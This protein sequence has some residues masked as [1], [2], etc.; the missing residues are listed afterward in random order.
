MVRQA[1]PYATTF[2]SIV[3]TADTAVHQTKFKFKTP[4][5][6]LSSAQRE[7]KDARVVLAILGYWETKIQG[8]RHL[9]KEREGQPESKPHARTDCTHFQFA[10]HSPGVEKH[11]ATEHLGRQ[12]EVKL[13][14]AGG[15][16]IAADRVVIDTGTRADPPVTEAPDAS[17]AP[18][19]KPLKK[20]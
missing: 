13:S 18:Q 14:R 7:T 9:P 12:G 16:K 10:V 11:H 3:N 20:R 2:K 4:V 19:V 17:D 8:D 1:T 15:H 6:L 5:S